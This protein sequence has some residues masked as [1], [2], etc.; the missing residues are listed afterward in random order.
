[1]ILSS[2][3]SKFISGAL[4]RFPHFSNK[5]NDVGN[6]LLKQVNWDLSF[7]ELTHQKSVFLRFRQDIRF[8]EKRMQVNG[9]ITKS[10]DMQKAAAEFAT[11][12]HNTECRKVFT[13]RHGRT[14]HFPSD[15]Y[16]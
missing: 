1:M 2:G 10:T 9:Q 11:S 13:R 4:S 16:R 12:N 5:Y 7:T 3:M 15:S 14:S 8:L 6:S